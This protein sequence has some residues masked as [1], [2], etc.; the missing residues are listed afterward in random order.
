MTNK[1]KERIE[2]L[3]HDYG[4]VLETV[5]QLQEE[6]KDRFDILGVGHG[7]KE[8]NNKITGDYALIFYVDKKKDEEELTTEEKI[9][10]A[11]SRLPSSF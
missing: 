6:Y 7:L 8:R 10:P 5:A 11:R 9:L 1:M 2:F 4:Q 3:L